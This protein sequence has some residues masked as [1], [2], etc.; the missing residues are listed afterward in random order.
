MIDFACTRI[1]VRDVLRCSFELTKSDLEVFA[2]LT[3]RKTWMTS[4]ALEE[5]TGFDR[6]TVQRSL[7]RLY[8]KGL[9]ER[10]QENSR[11]GGYAFLY[12]AVSG[13]SVAKRVMTTLDGFRE[14]LRQTLTKEDWTRAV[15]KRRTA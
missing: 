1:D 9:C 10:R 13:E 2:G 6:S 7:K 11:E 8:D 3:E 15:R 14:L 12:R 5:Q 4:A